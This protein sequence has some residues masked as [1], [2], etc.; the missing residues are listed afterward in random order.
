MYKMDVQNHSNKPSFCSFEVLLYMILLKTIAVIEVTNR[1]RNHNNKTTKISEL[2][3]IIELYEL[4]IT[5]QAARKRHMRKLY[6]H[7]RERFLGNRSFTCARCYKC[8]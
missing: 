7:L 8:S 6:K 4:Q 2:N 1:W 3:K 5:K